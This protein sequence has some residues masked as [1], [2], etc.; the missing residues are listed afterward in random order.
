ML[1]LRKDPEGRLRLKI[2]FYGPSMA[3]KTCSLRHL[4]DNVEGLKKGDFRSITDPVGRTLF[5]DFVPMQ[6]KTAK[7]VMFD[8]YT[9]AGQERHRG[10]RKVVLQEVD[11]LIFVVDSSE[12]QMDANKE[13]LKELKERFGDKLGKDIPLVITL[14]KRDVADALPRK[15]LLDE[16]NLLGFPVYETIATNG[17]GVKK[18]FQSIAREILFR[19]V[20][21]Q[22]IP[23]TQGV[24]S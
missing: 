17:F 8:V 2:V 4:Y 24:V 18:A 21:G 3:G 7:S 13:S 12:S 16:L 9:T 23:S 10:Q 1:R 14:N 11:G 19:L 22:S 5:F 20:Y 6:L 15:R